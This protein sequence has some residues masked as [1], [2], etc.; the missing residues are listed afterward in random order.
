METGIVVKR[1]DPKACLLR[2]ATF[3]LCGGALSFAFAVPGLAQS[4]LGTLVALGGG[5]ESTE[6]MQE[7]LELAR[8]RASRVLVLNTASSNPAQSGP[9]YE[10]FFQKRLGVAHASVLPLLSREQAY[11]PEVLDQIGAADLIYTTGGNQI[12]LTQV[13]LGT[14][15]HGALLAAWQRGAVIAGTSAGAMVWGPSYIMSGF[16][17]AA[18]QKGAVPGS[19]ELREGLGV[20]PNLVV[21]THFGREGRLG[22]LLVAA[23]QSPGVWGV[24]IDEGTAA[25]LNAEGVRVLGTGRVTLLDFQRARVKRPLRAPIALRDVEMHTLGPGESL[26]WRR[27]AAER[28][29]MLPA[30]ARDP[31]GAAALWLQ[32]KDSVPSRLL[33]FDKGLTAAFAPVPDELLVLSGNAAMPLA[34]NWQAALSAAGRTTVRI[35]SA[36]QVRS[37][38]LAQYL[39]IAGGLVMLEDAGGSLA[40][41]LRG[42]PSGIVRQHA[43]RLQCVAA[44]ATVGIVG[45]PAT[46]TVGSGGADLAP[47][48]RLAPD[49]IAAADVWKAGG[50]ERLMMDALLAEGALGVGL[51]PSNGVRLE[52]GQLRAW[53]EDPVVVLE[54]RGVSLANPAQ[55]SARDLRLHV[56]APGD[57]LPL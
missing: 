40:S 23:A 39:T 29:P 26:R 54:T 16:S 43:S 19:L 53:G 4:Q 52:G 33:G 22:R 50:F 31:L 55:N 57:T 45:E 3:L 11:E 7:V 34:K 20:L 38:L 56:V 24:G 51:T 17:L 2:L 44:A 10:R 9:A 28:T 8:G 49:L 41:A 47:G 35:L 25:V 46:R 37:P 5:S 13:L 18:L 48:L 1:V 42:E 32:G 36:D 12:R 27:G 21:D 6:M 30:K 15:A 14:P